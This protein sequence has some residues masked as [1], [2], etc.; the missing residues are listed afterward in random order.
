VTEYEAERAVIA[1]ALE[2]DGDGFSVMNE[3][4]SAGRLMNAIGALLAAREPRWRERTWADVRPG[5]RVKL[6]GTADESAAAVQA[7]LAVERHVRQGA[8]GHWDD[9]PHEFT[10]VHVTLAGHG[11]LEFPVTMPILIAMSDA[12][13]EL[14]ERLGW[15][16]RVAVTPN[17]V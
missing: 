11:R 1:A 3:T 15:P 8:A 14:A 5:D 7:Y 13:F 12:E 16:N 17:V 4:D 9:V 10:M 2:W 6:P